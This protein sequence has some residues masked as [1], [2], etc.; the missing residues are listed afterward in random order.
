MP[1][2]I[3]EV[4]LIIDSDAW[5]FT[6]P[7]FHQIFDT[8]VSFPQPPHCLKLF[9]SY[10]PSRIRSPPSFSAWLVN[11]FFSFNLGE[12]GLWEI[13]E[14]PLQALRAF[15]TL[16]APAR[17]HASLSRFKVLEAHIEIALVQAIM[18]QSHPTLCEVELTIDDASNAKR[19]GGV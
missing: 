2:Y 6:N 14:F 9:R 3:R 8:L 16:S 4:W 10:N 7:D 17:Q 13:N 11:S 1:S 5:S 18:D 19:L 15:Q 12:L